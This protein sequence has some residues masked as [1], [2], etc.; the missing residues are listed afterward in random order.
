MRN[1]ASATFLLLL[2]LTGGILAGTSGCSVRKKQKS[3]FCET[4]TVLRQQ[5]DSL[6]LTG[7]KECGE[8]TIRYWKQ[9]RLSPP[10]SSGRQF[11]RTVTQAVTA[12]RRT[13]SERDTLLQQSASQTSVHKTGSQKEENDTRRSFPTNIVFFFLLLFLVTFGLTQK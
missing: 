6:M 10:D 2:W 4:T 7:K 5:K 8:Q 3:E 1:N 11:V 9:F 13:E 12:S